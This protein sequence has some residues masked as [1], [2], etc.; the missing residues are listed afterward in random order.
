[1]SATACGAW[2]GGRAATTRSRDS[3]S[4]ARS[5][6]AATSS[7][8]PGPMATGRSEQHPR[9]DAA[10]PSPASG[11]TSPRRSRRRTAS[12]RRGRGHTLDDVFPADY[13]RE[14]TEKSLANIGVSSLDLQ[15]FHVWDDA[16][17]TRRALAARGRRAEGRGTGQGVRHQHQPLAAGERAASA[18]DDR[19]RS[20]RC[21]SST[22][23][24]TRPRG[25]AVPRLPAAT[26]SR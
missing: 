24:S 18:L 1:M 5:S 13:I 12:G 2:P 20:T 25:R 17:A 6:W 14:Y 15:Q 8:P 10:A 23:S 7:T 3:R 21:R 19:T 26:T 16:W 4:T 22:T 9:R 11:C